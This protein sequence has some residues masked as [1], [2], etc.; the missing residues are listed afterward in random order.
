MFTNIVHYRYFSLYDRVTTLDVNATIKKS[1]VVVVVADERGKDERRRRICEIMIEA[2]ISFQNHGG[3]G[4]RKRQ[5]VLQQEGLR[6]HYPSR[7]QLNH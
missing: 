5:M 6:V 4:A 2:P 1:A 7:G 3:K